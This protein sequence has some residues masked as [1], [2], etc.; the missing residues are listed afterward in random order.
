MYE[1]GS[2][3]QAKYKGRRFDFDVKLHE[4]PAA[5]DNVDEELKKYVDDCIT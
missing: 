1:K 2:Y 5:E 3:E 4:V